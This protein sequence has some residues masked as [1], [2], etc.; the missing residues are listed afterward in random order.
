[1]VTGGVSYYGLLRGAFDFVD[2]LK[3]DDLSYYFQGGF[4]FFNLTYL[5]THFG[6]RGR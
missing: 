4:G 1:M 2:P 3:D 6:A 5:D